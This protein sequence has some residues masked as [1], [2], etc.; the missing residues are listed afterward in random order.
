MKNRSEDSARLPWTG[1]RF[2]PEVE[3]QIALEHLHRYILACEI[4][5]GKLV[6]DIACGEGYGAAMLAAVAQRVV[7]VDCDREV[8]AHAASK[9]Q[10]ANVDFK[11]GTC[12]E[13]PLPEGCI[14]LVVSF[15]TL[16]HHDEH[17]KMLLE[18]KRVL[19]PH[20]LFL[21]SSP[22]KYEYSVV[23]NSV[24]SFHVKELYRHE[25]ECLTARFFKHV[26]FYG[27]RIIY[28]SGIF[29][30]AGSSSAVTFKNEGMFHR[31]V[32][33][34]LRPHYLLALASDGDLPSLP[35]SLYEQSVHD[36]ELGESWSQA[37]LERDGRIAHLQLETVAKEEEII[38]LRQ[39]IVAMGEEIVAK[40]EEMQQRLDAKE[41][42]IDYFRGK[43]GLQER[44]L[45]KVLQSRS[46]R[47]TSGFRWI[48]HQIHRSSWGSREWVLMKVKRVY[49]LLPLSLTQKRRIKN[50]G[51]T[52]FGFLV[53]RSDV[54]QQW[55]MSR[56]L[57][58]VSQNLIA[59]QPSIPFSPSSSESVE[60]WIADGKKEWAQYAEMKSRIQYVLQDQTKAANP[61]PPVLLDVGNVDLEEVASRIQLPFFSKDPVVSI[62]IP[63]FNQ[64][65]LT[66]ECLMSIVQRTPEDV[67]YEIIVG[68]DASLDNTASI[69]AN[70]PNLRVLSQPT[71]LGFLRNCNRAAELARG[72]Y[73]LFLN[74]DVQ[75]LSGW[76]LPL[77]RVFEEEKDVGAVGPMILFPDGQLQEAGARLKQDGTAEMI[78]IYT[79]P[80]ENQ[81]RYRREVD[82]CSGA[83]LLVEREVFNQ[84]GGF[85]EGYA[86]AYCEDSD[87]CFRIRQLGKHVWYCP[88]SQVVH[89]LSRSSEG[90][91]SKRRLIVQNTQR[92]RNIWQEQLNSRDDVKVV[93]FY[94]PQFHPIPENDLWW[95]KGFTEW[96][97]VAKAQPN[98]P[99]HF[100]PRQP[101]DLGYYDLRIPTVMEEQARLAQRYGIKGFCYYYYWFSGKRLLDNPLN[102]LLQNKKS[103][104][105]FCLCWANE[106]WTRRWDGNDQEILM[107]QSHSAE[108]DFRVIQDVMRYF[109][110]P[111][112]LRINGK[113]LML[114]YRVS[115]F[116]DFYR[117]AERWRQACWEA[118]IGD[119]FLTLVE[120]FEQARNG[121]APE[122]FG[123]DATV[124]FPP[125]GYLAQ[126]NIQVPKET[127][128][129]QGCIEDY[130]DLALFFATRPYPKYKRFPC[131]VPGWDNTARRQLDSY[132]F[133][134][135]TPGAFQAW[136]ERA[137]EIAKQQFCG[138]ER[139]V[140][141]NAWNEWAEGAYL[142]PD[143]R[144]GH[145]FLEAIR[146][147]RESSHLMKNMF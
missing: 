112:Y 24:N 70:I 12:G 28:G 68:D 107:A 51:F 130:K 65:K 11:V 20:G 125:Q 85:D 19:K 83:C 64:L 91:S 94:L 55:S 71:N 57:Q 15:E 79:S 32:S 108:D 119:I 140:F 132:C 39:E 106:N 38:Q 29:N 72:C 101:A 120:S 136:L 10:K 23:P 35:T 67:S 47:W 58:H 102:S 146:N 147:A 49:Q 14:D 78:G 54:F 81:Y 36:S 114:V 98:F 134:D 25:F 100:Q 86:P 104:M 2:V 109:R 66:L 118:G 4:A 87:L 122:V 117:T 92:L 145:T 129:F 124:E 63:V 59:K 76:L 7:G 77:I 113:P 41:K 22:D 6:L 105:P 50:L 123:C 128:Q 143:T 88:E 21:I 16:E 1:E 141:V 40:K 60:L 17:E 121:V 31:R 43:A 75:V 97:N 30:E 133:H 89:H 8:I 52:W 48:I 103:T 110:S 74:N 5:K 45:Q 82:Y 69:V 33:G 95:G 142:E 62:V 26:D 13:I 137:I 80:E 93:A 73:V 44:E 3:G 131:V 127:S 61:L 46:W 84:L 126:G 115:Q 34:M 111:Q 37:I 138:E 27:Q 144:F 56:H 116:P 135:A 90:E 42:D 99:G 139:L 18:V 53:R 96:T 9:Y